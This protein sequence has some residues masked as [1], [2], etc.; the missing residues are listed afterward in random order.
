M[1]KISDFWDGLKERLRNPLISSFLVSWIFFNWRVTVALIWYNSDQIKAEGYKT[2]NDFIFYNTTP[3]KTF[4]GPF[5][6]AL[7]FM[8]TNPIIKNIGRWFNIWIKKKFDNPIFKVLGDAPVKYGL[9]QERVNEI[10]KIHNE[11]AEAVN[12][13]KTTKTQLTRFELQIAEKDS[14]INKLSE[15]NSHRKDDIEKLNQIVNEQT[16]IALLNGQWQLTYIKDVSKSRQFE[17]K[18]GVAYQTDMEFR[19]N[20]IF[21]IRNYF[22]QRVVDGKQNVFFVTIDNNVEPFCKCYNLTFKG[23][24]LIGMEN[25]AQDV[26]FIRLKNDQ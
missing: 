26:E 4:W 11:L 10:Q 22:Y 12:K 23:G 17:I 19:A 24:A 5:I 14:E 3:W 8:I 20:R 13:E 2:L 25:Y 9:Y 18:D 6:L 16:D 15:L 1:D 7:L 21:S